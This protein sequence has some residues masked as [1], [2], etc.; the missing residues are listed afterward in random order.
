[1]APLWAVF[2]IGS[3]IIENPV[4]IYLTPSILVAQLF[5]DDAALVDLAILQS[6][7]MKF[8]KPFQIRRILTERRPA[9]TRSESAVLQLM[10]PGCQV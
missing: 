6:R 4:E 5:V 2:Q 8:A 9:Q 1:M 10:P 7:K 3:L